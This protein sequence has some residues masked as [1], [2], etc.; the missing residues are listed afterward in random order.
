[1]KKTI[2]T[3]GLAAVLL[4]GVTHAYSQGPGFGPGPGPGSGP[5]WGERP[6]WGQADP[7]SALNL[8]PEQKTRMHELRTKFKGEN[9][10]LIGA[11]V[12][13]RIELQSLWSNPR[14]EAAAIQAKEKELRDL[15]NQMRDKAVQMRLEAR[16]I[17]TPEQIAQMGQGR[18][19]GPCGGRGSGG[20]FGHGHGR[21]W[22][23]GPG[24]R[25]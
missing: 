18:G 5:H 19:F 10:Q 13:K 14:A 12:T 20:G 17:L 15:Q 22:G 25:L 11:M 21:G 4:L 9:A 8:N 2:I 1:M 7:R 23:S 3:L 24:D 6:H 16:K